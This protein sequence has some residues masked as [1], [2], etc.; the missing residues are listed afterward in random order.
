MF[1]PE[2]GTQYV[3]LWK[4]CKNIDGQIACV[5]L[6]LPSKSDFANITSS[7]SAARDGAAAGCILSSA[8]ALLAFCFAVCHNKC[9]TAFTSMLAALLGLA[10][11]FSW[12]VYQQEANDT[13]PNP[14]Y[15]FTFGFLF[16]SVAAASNIAS[17]ATSCYIRKSSEYEYMA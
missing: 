10:A 14:G 8:A 4:E 12:I 13:T 16:A 1:M 6:G 15:K 5:Q 7:R 11:V 2:N 9:C 3:S 17:F